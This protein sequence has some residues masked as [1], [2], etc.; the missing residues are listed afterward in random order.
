MDN[1]EGFPYQ[2]LPGS[3]VTSAKDDEVGNLVRALKW[4]DKFFDQ[5]DGLVAVFDFDYEQI[6]AFRKSVGCVAMLFPPMLIFGTLFA[7]YPCFYR[8]QVDWDVYSQH[9]AITRDGIK[10]VKD[11]RKTGCGLSCTDRGK[12]SKT[13]PFDKL[14]DCDVTEPAG[15]TCC[16]IDNVLSVVTVDTASSGGGGGEGGPR[17]ELSLAGLKEPQKFKRLV[18]AMKRASSKGEN[19]ALVP[20]PSFAAPIQSAMDRGLSNEETNSILRDIRSELI[21]MN[22]NMKSMKSLESRV[23]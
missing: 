1:T 6:A 17:H 5:E 2:T 15:A 11:R 20:P 12:S 7:C 21:E 4:E 8:Q 9:V 19:Q 22:A 10:Y 23:V 18:W 3:K 13:V 14:T 16:C